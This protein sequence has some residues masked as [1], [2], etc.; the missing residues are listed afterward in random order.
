MQAASVHLNSIQSL[1]SNACM[2]G[3]WFDVF[4]VWCFFTEHSVKCA[5]GCVL[6]ATHPRLK[7]QSSG[8]SQRACT[9][10]LLWFVGFNQ[11]REISRA[12][13]LRRVQSGFH[14]YTTAT[15]VLHPR[16]KWS[17][18]WL[19]RDV[20]RVQGLRLSACQKPS[21]TVHNRETQVLCW[22]S[23]SFQT[24][25]EFWNCHVKWIVWLNVVDDTK[26]EQISRADQYQVC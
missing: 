8:G 11:D 3:T 17:S 21:P 4:L 10:G 18:S 20:A 2:E 26:Q 23:E 1:D 19:R 22:S 24:P 14:K 15:G 12:R 13:N 9:G 6:Q 25:L 5:W 16:R 7:F